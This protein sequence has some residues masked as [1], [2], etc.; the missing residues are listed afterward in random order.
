MLDLS[1]GWTCIKIARKRSVRF[2]AP[3]A[4]DDPKFC[5]TFDRAAGRIDNARVRALPNACQWER[6]RL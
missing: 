5:D 6:E 1:A 3:A 2:P 4:L